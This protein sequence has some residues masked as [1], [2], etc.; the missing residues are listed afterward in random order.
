MTCASYAR[1]DDPIQMMSFNF[2]YPIHQSADILVDE[3][4]NHRMHIGIATDARPIFYPV[5]G[6]Y[7]S[8]LDD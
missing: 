8:S 6:A 3:L 2:A 1:C 5:R 4:N 7:F